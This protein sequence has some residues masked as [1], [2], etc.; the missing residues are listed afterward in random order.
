MVANMPKTSARDRYDELKNEI[1]HHDYQYHVLDK[2]EIRD[3]DYDKL[4]QELLKIEQDH[5]EWVTE[6]SPSQRV[7]GEVLEG[8]EKVAHRKPMLSLQ[9]T[10]SAEEILEFDK[11][12][13]KKLDREV[14]VEYF[15]EPKFDGLSIELVYEKGVLVRAITRGDGQVGENVLSNVRTIKSV[16][17]TLKEKIPLLEVRGEILI[18][19]ED[20]KKLNEQQE[21]NGL[22][23]FANPRNAAAG[24]VRQ[25]DPRIAAS[26]PL[27]LFCYAPGSLEG[28]KVSSQLEWQKLLK[29]LDFPVSPLGAVC[30]NAKAAQEFYFN[31]EKQRHKLPFD[32]DGVVI[33]VNSFKLQ[34]QIGFIARSPSWATA[35]KYKPEQATTTVEKIIVQVG[36]TGALTPV[37]VMNPVKVGGV[38]VTNATLHNIEEV[39]RK[40]VREGDTV[41]IH[42]AGDVIPEI[43]EVVLDKRPKNSKPFEMPS[44]CPTCSEKVVKVEG[45]VIT[46]CVNPLCPS[47]MKESLKHFVSRRAMNMEKLGDKLIEQFFDAGL[48]QKFS[49]LYRLKKDDVL[50]LDRQGD[51]SAQNIIDSVDSS[52]HPSL[53]RFIYALGIRF[54]G[55]Q[56]AR[57]L[58][59]HFKSIDKFIETTEEELVEIE[60]IGPKVAQSIASALK[61]KKFVKE[62]LELQKLGVE[63]EKQK[64]TP[65]GEQKLSGMN[66]VITGTLPMGRDEIKDLIVS[67]GGKSSGSV[68]KKTNFVLAGE[69]AGSKLDKARELGVKVIDWDEFQKLIN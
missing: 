25:L 15:C 53:A 37:A 18:L 31:I 17:L 51:K 12:V 46:R 58:S 16:P 21:E 29:D 27:K 34:D 3:F 41:V 44:K 60:D 42:R 59:T 45:E 24:T 57:S 23:T 67:L 11:R 43:L 54:V 20:F 1:R 33:K 63:I 65:K 36:R 66:I 47:V 13:Q 4:Y 10:Y 30:K 2:P 39:Q 35:T 6:D 7:G 40:D 50:S 62:I 48:V 55:E 5:P 9:N 56:T 68:S 22:M 49:D 32:I 69:E 19:K 64:S 61:Q 8:F 26:R 14:E 28:V 52:R 38:T